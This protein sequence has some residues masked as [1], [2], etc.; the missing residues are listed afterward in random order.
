MITRRLEA[1]ITGRLFKG[2]AVVV[3]GPRQ[4]GKTTL[5]RQIV[6]RQKLDHIWLDADEPIV[7]TQLAGASI[8]DLKK[9]IADGFGGFISRT[10]IDHWRRL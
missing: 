5:L 7:R 10:G 6:D 8:A 2:K 1:V 9:L 3:L 4:S